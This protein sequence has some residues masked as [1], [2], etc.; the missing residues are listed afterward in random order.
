MVFYSVGCITCLPPPLCCCLPNCIPRPQQALLHDVEH[1][2]CD[3][4]VLC[5]H[6]MLLLQDSHLKLLPL[7]CLALHIL[8]QV[9]EPGIRFQAMEGA[10]MLAFPFAGGGGVGAGV[11]VNA[12]QCCHPGLTAIPCQMHLSPH[13]MS[14]SWGQC[15]CWLAYAPETCG[16][17][18]PCQLH[19]LHPVPT[20]LS[21]CECPYSHVKYVTHCLGLLPLSVIQGL[22]FT[23]DVGN[24]VK[25][26]EDGGKGS[27]VLVGFMSQHA[28]RVH[29]FATL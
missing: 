22:S 17:T 14:L 11:T 20:L 29:F 8:H 15:T 3:T 5:M 21:T 27:H 23:L 4:F 6:H 24:Q 13:P 19:V 1:V 16:H 9:V 12:C 18:G 10:Y 28:A 25:V 2:Q 7:F 26:A